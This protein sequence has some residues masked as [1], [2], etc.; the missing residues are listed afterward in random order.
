MKPKEQIEKEFP[1]VKVQEEWA[2]AFAEA[3][4]VEDFN[5]QIVPLMRERG[6]EFILAAAGEAKR[7]GY[8]VNRTDGT[9][10]EGK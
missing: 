5:A 9:Y 6:K 8:K 2:A 3:V 10:Q 4:T 1:S 7:R